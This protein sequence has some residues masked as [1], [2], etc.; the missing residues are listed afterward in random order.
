MWDPGAPATV[1]SGGSAHDAMAVILVKN[2]SAGGETIRVSLTRLELNTNGGIWEV[3]SIETPGMS[4][5]S[6]QSAAHLTSPVTVTGSAGAFPGKMT[7]IAVL[8]HN[9]TAIGHVT[10]T[11][12]QSSFTTSIPYAASLPGTTQEGIVALYISAG[13]GAMA[14][15]VMVKVLLSGQC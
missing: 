5:T 15:S 7:T 13:N 9:R 2:P 3:T 11:T 1:V 8:D 6:P 4:I 14:A 12:G 10:L